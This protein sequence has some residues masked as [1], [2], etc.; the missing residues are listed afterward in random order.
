MIWTLVIIMFASFALWG[1]SQPGEYDWTVSS[2]RYSKD[3]DAVSSAFDVVDALVEAGE[4][5]SR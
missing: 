5:E 1:T 3:Q 2:H 4:T